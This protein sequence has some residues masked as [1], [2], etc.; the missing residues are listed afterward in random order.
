M[1][2]LGDSENDIPCF[3]MLN[4]KRGHTI[5]IDPIDTDSWLGLTILSLRPQFA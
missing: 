5:S 3:S 4:K 2:Y 1:I